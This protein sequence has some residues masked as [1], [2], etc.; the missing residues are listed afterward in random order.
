M[1][2][3][4]IANKDEKS[5]TNKCNMM[6]TESWKQYGKSALVIYALIYK[7]YSNDLHKLVVNLKD[8]KL[9]V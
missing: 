7:Q 8:L 3:E 1:K 9:R 6:A 2:A 4:K 5:K